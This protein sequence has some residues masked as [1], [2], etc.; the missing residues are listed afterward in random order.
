MKRIINATIAVVLLVGLTTLPTMAA[1]STQKIGIVDLKRLFDNYWKTK[2][3]NARLKELRSDMLK[4]QKA[5]EEK[6][7]K[8][9]DEYKKILESANDQAVSAEEREKR[10]KSAEDK[11][12]ELRQIEVAMEQFV[13]NASANLSEEERRLRDNIVKELRE[14]IATKARAGGFTLVLDVSGETANSAPA[15]LYTNGENDLTDQVLNELNAKAPPELRGQGS[16]DS[17]LKEK[18]SDSILK[19]K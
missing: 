11:L 6:H 1:Q 14:A 17:I 2:Q 15:V 5:I 3:A 18:P 12:L 19:N 10:K 8:A 13:R 16:S 7:S 4:E 9:S